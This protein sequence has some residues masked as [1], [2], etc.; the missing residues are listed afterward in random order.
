MKLLY[1]LAVNGAE[2]GRRIALIGV[3]VHSKSKLGGNANHNVVE[4]N[5]TGG[6][7]S[8][9]YDLLVGYAENLSI[10]RGH[11]NVTLCNDN[12]L[13]DGN[14]AA[15]A[16]QLYAGGVLDVAALVNGGNYAK[17][18]SVGEGYLNLIVRTAGTENA[19][20]KRALGAY[21]LNLF[22]ASE[23]TGLAEILLVVK[24][25]ACAEESLKRLLSDVE[26]TSRGFYEKFLFHNS[27]LS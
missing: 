23:L 3:D 5:G 24:L 21:Y 8:Y 7:E 20:L 10:S 2:G 12:A 25:S 27:S 1:D 6:V 16:N 14:L 13:V 22:L 15:G 11:M 19:H 18:A 9:L 26:M 17:C 4:D